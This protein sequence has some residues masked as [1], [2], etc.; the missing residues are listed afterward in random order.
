MDTYGTPYDYQ[1]VMHYYSYVPTGITLTSAIKD[2]YRGKYW[3]VYAD[4][5]IR[6]GSENG[7]TYFTPWDIY[8]IKRL[9]GLGSNSE[10]PYTPTVRDGDNESDIEDPCSSS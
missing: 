9:Y 10:P 6:W 7:N 4:N 5:Q 3:I 1:S 8:A 2:E